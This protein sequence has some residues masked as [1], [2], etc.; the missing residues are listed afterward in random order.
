MKK[1]LDNYNDSSVSTGPG[2]VG[3][4]YDT[5]G[6][7]YSPAWG[8]QFQWGG[9]LQPTSYNLP[10]AAHAGGMSSEISTSIGGEQGEPAY[11]IPTF[12][13]GKPLKDAVKEFQKTKQHLGG[14]FKTWQNAE[15]F[16]EMRHQY[17]EKGQDIPSPLKW[18][19][20]MQMGGALP[21]A[22]GMM[23][24]RTNNP[25]PSNGPYA[26]KTKASAQNG[27]KFSMEDIKKNAISKKNPSAKEMSGSMY[28]PHGKNDSNLENII[29]VVD[30]TGLSS[31]DDVADSYEK[32]GMSPQT[33]LEIFGAFPLI[34]K[35]GNVG[36]VAEVATKA[37]AITG[38]QKRNG[39][40][41]SETLKAIGK[42]GPS[43]GIATD[44]YQAAEQ[45]QNGGEMKFYQEGLD[46]KPNNISQDGSIIDPMGQWAHPGEITT[47]PSNNIT[48]K[49]VPYPVLGVSDK[50]D[51]K[52]MKP[53]KDYKFKGS[54]VTEYPMAEF[55]DYF[56]DSGQA[57]I[58]GAVG[59]A[60]GNALFGPL[61]GMAGKL[62]G[63]VAGNLL[64][65]AADA[66]KLARYQS[67][68]QT[69]TQKAAMQQSLQSGQ[70]SSYMKNG[71]WLDKYK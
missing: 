64:G 9:F 38:R 59:E 21:G 20:D 16:G 30:P 65:G 2:F 3:A 5:K 14:P 18:W 10:S 50:G 51:K 29:E 42:Y 45:W 1:W 68:T 32:T 28:S 31:W 37:F 55:G 23:Y 12:K 39:K 24:A 69:N 35:L 54:K 70:F 27:K 11:L 67:Q 36:K 63:N 25:A 13:H 8:G 34:G 52:M 40:A 61:G 46:W 48:M 7:H 62:L 4:G 58:G 43:A 60:A 56:Q 53:G 19:D 47:I 33:G 57:Q 26:K 71:G 49:G 44:A 17:V 66:N 6:R 15:K 41:I 22:T